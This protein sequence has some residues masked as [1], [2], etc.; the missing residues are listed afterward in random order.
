VWGRLC[1]KRGD[2]AAARHHFEQAAAIFEMAGS[3][4]ELNAVQT[5]MGIS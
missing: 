1:H 2:S 5:A 3:V 4:D